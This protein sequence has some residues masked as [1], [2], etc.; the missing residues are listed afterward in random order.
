MN[1]AHYFGNTEGSGILATADAEGQVD[2][3]IYETPQVIDENIIALN[4]LNRRSFQNLQSNPHAAYMFIEWAM[5]ISNTRF[6]VSRTSNAA[7]RRDR[8][9]RPD[10]AFRRARRF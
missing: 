6:D 4:M 7:I 3:A 10:R 1:L 8:N 5:S 9:N 2:M